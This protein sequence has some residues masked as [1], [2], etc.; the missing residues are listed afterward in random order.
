MLEQRLLNGTAGREHGGMRNASSQF[1][2]RRLPGGRHQ[3]VQA[4]R[5]PAGRARSLVEQF[6]VREDRIPAPQVAS[7]SLQSQAFGAGDRQHRLQDVGDPLLIQQVLEKRFL[8]FAWSWLA[9]FVVI[10]LEDV[11]A[12]IVVATHLLGQVAVHHPGGHAL[13]TQGE[14]VFDADVAVAIAER[15]QPVALGGHQRRIGAT[16]AEKGQ[17]R[18]LRLRGGHVGLG[19]DH[20]SGRF[21]FGGGPVLLRRDGQG[22]LQRGVC[23]FELFDLTMLLA[24][25][26]GQVDFGN[27]NGLACHVF[28]MPPMRPFLWLTV[29]PGGCAQRR[30]GAT[31][32][33]CHSS[34]I[35]AAGWLHAAAFTPMHS[36]QASMSAMYA[37][38]SRSYF[39]RLDL[40]S[41]WSSWCSTSRMA[42]LFSYP[43]L[44]RPAI[45]VWIRL[46]S[47]VDSGR[48]L[49]A[50]WGSRASLTRRFRSRACSLFL[51]A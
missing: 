25:Q 38:I 6:G 42:A 22:A 46:V 35:A 7:G 12:G 36:S 14:R 43:G 10:F 18:T 32:S 49:A 30:P 17:E 8:W 41:R 40:S 4:V 20:G 27:A 48:G 47:S 28:S 23:A 1:P 51:R 5:C 2:R 34:R 31:L 26:V 44:P 13:V 9:P 16:Q 33:R 24:N 21:G 11:E 3:D 15:R 45:T 37:V 39:G 19:A 50:S 29:N